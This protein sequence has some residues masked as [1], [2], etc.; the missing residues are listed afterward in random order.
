MQLG[1]DNPGSILKKKQKKV[2]I[3][4]ERRNAENSQAVVVRLLDQR[5]RYA[6]RFAT[7]ADP[8]V[9]NALV[10]NKVLNDQSESNP[11]IS[12]ARTA[13]ASRE[14]QSDAQQREAARAR[15]IKRR[16]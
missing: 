2:R 6:T 12:S 13:R 1:I 10:S 8:V 15:A 5:H 16:H 4:T 9:A 14:V 11:V 3:E 7:V